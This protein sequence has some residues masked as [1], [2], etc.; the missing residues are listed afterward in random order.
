M[1]Y[2]TSINKSVT[3]SNSTEQQLIANTLLSLQP[4]RIISFFPNPLMSVFVCSRR[5]RFSLKYS[6]LAN[7]QHSRIFIPATMGNLFPLPQTAGSAMPTPFCGVRLIVYRFFTGLQITG[8]RG[9]TPAP[10]PN[11]C[12]KE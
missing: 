4:F 12:G 11:F 8:F 7:V 2:K 5:G 9:Y 1:L 10:T 3:H 6:V